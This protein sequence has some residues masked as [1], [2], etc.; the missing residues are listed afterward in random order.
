[1]SRTLRL[2]VL[3]G[4]DADDAVLSQIE[5]GRVLQVGLAGV[6]RTRH[7]SLHEVDVIRAEHRD[8]WSWVDDLE[9]LRGAIRGADV[10]V[11]SIGPDLEAGRHGPTLVTEFADAMAAFIGGC[12]D[13]GVRVIVVNGAT[14]DP[15]DTVSCYADVVETRAL[16]THRLDLE[17]I[18]L[19]M[20]DGISVLD[21]D[22]MVAEIGGG[23]NVEASL[24]YSPSLCEAI[25][26][27]L[28]DV[29]EE[30]GFCDDRPLLVQQ[31]RRE[32]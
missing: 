10:L 28:A 27:E 5:G 6:L 12:K 19:S 13:E 21:V 32:R 11:R 14:Y 9:G 17:L 7:A 2:V 20:L 25:R 31:G 15:H 26:D 23:T 8:V 1:M 18:Q 3:G 29:L 24:R 30:Y 16:S 4:T 22:R